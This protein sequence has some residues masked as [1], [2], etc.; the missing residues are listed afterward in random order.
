M[1]VFCQSSGVIRSSSTFNDHRSHLSHAFDSP[2]FFRLSACCLHSNIACNHLVY[3]PC[4]TIR[5]NHS[6]R[7]PWHRSHSGRLSL[8]ATHQSPFAVVSSLLRLEAIEATIEATIEVTIS[9]TVDPWHGLPFLHFLLRPSLS[10]FAVV[11]SLLRLEAIEASIVAIIKVTISARVEAI[12][13][14]NAT[15]STNDASLFVLAQVTT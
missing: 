6:K 14:I 11:S 10:P 12:H 15:E 8:R 9:A 5:F 3:A 13:A 1:P 4:M 2:E 7:H